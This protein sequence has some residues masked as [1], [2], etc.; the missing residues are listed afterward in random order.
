MPN[1][2]TTIL[3][4]EDAYISGGANATSNFGSQT[5]ITVGNVFSGSNNTCR[6]IL[7]GSLASIPSFSDILTAVLHFT[8]SGSG[9]LSQAADF[10]CRRL[11]TRGWVESTVTYNTIDGATAWSAAGAGSDYTL[12]NQSTVNVPVS[13]SSIEFNVKDQVQDSHDLLVDHN[14]VLMG[15]EGTGVSDYISPYSSDFGTSN[16]RPYL[17]VTY[18]YYPVNERIARSMLRRL[19]KV[20]AGSTYTN[21]FSVVRP[22]SEG[23]KG[24]VHGRCVLEQA[25]EA[26]KIGQV[27]GNP[28]GTEWR[29]EFYISVH[30]GPED[31]TTPVDTVANLAA[32]DAELAITTE[33]LT[34]DWAQFDGLAMECEQTGRDIYSDGE[35]RVVLLTY[36]VLYRTS[37]TDPYTVR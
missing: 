19:E 22:G 37:E 5:V 6:G 17:A 31:K 35:F 4:T 9:S 20:V 28:P 32:A 29:Q 2:S 33:Q 16:S 10:Y 14:V 36:A 25:Q 21:T 23:V 8:R 18:T 12:T 15:P 7:R 3:I 24:L 26:Q 34:G 27:D 1:G 30:V 11:T 13:G